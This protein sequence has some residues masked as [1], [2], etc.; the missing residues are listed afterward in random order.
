M[1]KQSFVVILLFLGTI[2]VD[3]SPQTDEEPAGL[4]T[5]AA[6]FVQAAQE[7]GKASVSGGS[8]QNAET[9]EMRDG[10]ALAKAPRRQDHGESG[11]EHAWR[12]S[13]LARENISPMTSPA[14]K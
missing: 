2:L 10:R 5:E 4:L 8:L 9:G 3:A 6:Q 1:K 14:H 12:L 13:V 11:R 7:A